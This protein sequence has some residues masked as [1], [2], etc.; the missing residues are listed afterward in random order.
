M[1]QPPKIAHKQE[2]R[3]LIELLNELR[4]VLLGVQVL[5]SF[6]LTVPLIGRC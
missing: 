5:F 6:L 4:I 3:E 1:S 2:N